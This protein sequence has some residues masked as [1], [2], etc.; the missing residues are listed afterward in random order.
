M[1]SGSVRA[2]EKPIQPHRAFAATL[3]CRAGVPSMSA[4]RLPA[5]PAAG[6]GRSRETP[7]SSRSG[8]KSPAGAEFFR[9]SPQSSDR[10]AADR[11]AT[12]QGSRGTRGAGVA[13]ASGAS[14]PS[15][16]TSMSR[17]SSDTAV[18]RAG[19]RGGS[20]ASAATWDATS[21]LGMPEA[22]AGAMVICGLRPRSRSDT[23]GRD[24]RPADSASKLAASEVSKAV[25]PARANPVTPM[26]I[27]LRSCSTSEARRLASRM[28]AIHQASAGVKSRR[29][30]AI[31][32]S[33]PTA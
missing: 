20:A 30:M 13:D 26:R 21:N 18:V 29:A 4:P 1:A 9:T 22:A 31:P 23:A 6:R 28:V 19:H 32:L 16:G 24:G 5:L 11:E 15:L 27:V 8:S 12:R 10:A 17:A 7:V 25:L 2:A 14:R 3:R 33:P